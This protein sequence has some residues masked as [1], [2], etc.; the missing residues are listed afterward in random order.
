MNAEA[1]KWNLY[2]VESDGLEDCFVVAR[3]S[4]SARLVEANM[5]GFE[6]GYA[7]AHKILCIPET[8]ERSYKRQKENRDRRWPGYVY[9]RRFFELIGAEFRTIDDKEEMLL[10]DTVYAVADYVPCSIQKDRCIGVKAAEKILNHPD[11]S[12]LEYDDEDIWPGPERHLM[13][14]LGICLVRC[15]QIENYIVHSFLLGISKKQ[16]A[17]YETF[18][19]LRNG[20]KK[21]TLGNMLRCIEEAWEIHPLVKAGLELFLKQRNMLIHGITTEERFDIRTSWGQRELLAFLAFFDIHSRIVKRAFRASYYASMH[22]AIEQWGRPAGLPKKIFSKK[23][24]DEIGLFA[25]FFSPKH[26]SI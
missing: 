8:V 26:E 18:N 14:M 11:F 15:Q 9:G 22:F 20:W 24:K 10:E 17:Q 19:E 3:N 16:K 5:N 23:H 25:Q 1:S 6:L 4:R 2:W 7:K 13:T 12:S 21:K